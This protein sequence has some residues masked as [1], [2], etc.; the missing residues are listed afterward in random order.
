MSAIETDYLVIGAGAAGMSFT[1]ALIDAD[2]VL[3]RRHGGPPACPWGPL[4]RC[5]PIRAPPSA[6][7]VLR[8]QLAAVGRRQGR[9]A[10]TSMPAYT[11]RRMVW[12]SVN[13]SGE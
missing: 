13:T 11:S 1:D 3:R 10:R 2:R 7:R 8:S 4:E 5:L 6:G 9:R 12:K